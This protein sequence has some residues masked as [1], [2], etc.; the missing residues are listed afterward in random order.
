MGRKI[1]GD[2]YSAMSQIHWNHPRA[3][4]FSLM[5]CV[6]QAARSIV[7]DRGFG[8][9]GV[10]LNKDGWRK[11]DNTLMALS[12]HIYPTLLTRFLLAHRSGSHIPCDSRRDR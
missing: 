12:D 6:S 8:G 7:P 11:I 2:F 10:T 3:A 4:P 9:F 5:F 1:P